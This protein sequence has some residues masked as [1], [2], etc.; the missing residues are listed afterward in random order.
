MAI[1]QTWMPGLILCSINPPFFGI[2]RKKSRGRGEQITD[3][4]VDFIDTDTIDIIDMCTL[5][6]FLCTIPLTTTQTTKWMTNKFTTSA[7]QDD[8]IYCSIQQTIQY[9]TRQYEN[10]TNWRRVPSPYGCHVCHTLNVKTHKNRN[11]I[12]FSISSSVPP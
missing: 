10:I 3:L 4:V 6:S 1:S 5:Y 2:Q 12:D 9:K 11:M 8:E 7:T